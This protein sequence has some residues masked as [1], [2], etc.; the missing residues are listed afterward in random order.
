MS[1]ITL[2]SISSPNGGATS[3][4]GMKLQQSQSGQS[5]LS[6]GTKTITF[7]SPFTSTPKVFVQCTSASSPGS[8]NYAVYYLVASSVS[9][10]G[11][12]VT[13]SYVSGSSGASG[14]VQMCGGDG[15]T[16]F[17]TT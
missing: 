13:G 14:T 6:N 16:W 10:T 15:F 9:T 11:F 7:S 3:F 17:A 4:N 12:T 5:T 8:G 2:G 1:S